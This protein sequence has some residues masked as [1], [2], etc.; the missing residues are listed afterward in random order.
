M[1]FTGFRLCENSAGSGI[2]PSRMNRTRGITRHSAPV[3]GIAVIVITLAIVAGIGLSAYRA[4]VHR[5]GDEQNATL[6]AIGKLKA[7]Q[8][9]QWRKNRAFDAW[10]LA[11]GKFLRSVIDRLSDPAIAE[12]LRQHL[13][14]QASPDG[15]NVLLFDTNGKFLLSSQPES[16]DE[17]STLNPALQ[18][19]VQAALHSNEAVVSDIYKCPF[20]KTHIDFTAA[21]PGP[22]GN[23]AGVL[24]L[25]SE[26][27]DFLYP[28]L[29]TWPLPSETAESLLAA[30][31]GDE[32]VFLNNLRHAPDAA[33]NLRLPMSRVDLPTVQW[34]SG[35]PEVRS[36][37]DY[38]GEPVFSNI[39]PIADSP[40]IIVAKIDKKEAFRDL[41][42]RIFEIVLVALLILLLAAIFVAALFI[43]RQRHI[44]QSLRMSEERLRRVIDASPVP[45]AVNNPRGEITYL[46]PA[47]TQAFGYT[48]K[49]IPNL[50]EW[51]PKAYPDPDYRKEVA[52]E[53]AARIEKSLSTGSPFEP[54]EVSVR[55][56]DGA[57]RTVLGMAAQMPEEAG[58]SLIVHLY[59]IT[60]RKESEIRTMRLARMYQALSECNQAIVQST[61]AG[62]LFGRVCR[63]VVES[64]GMKMAWVGMADQNA[65]FL[66]KIAA[67]GEGT[68]YLDGLKI[69]LSPVGAE[70]RGPAATSI[71]ENRPVWCQDFMGDPMTAPWHER[72]AAF[73]WAASAAL[74]LCKAGKPC[75]AFTFYSGQK[76]A[77]DEDVRNLLSEI[78]VNI[79]FAMDGFER[80]K[81]RRIAEDELAR[82]KD[83][84]A[85]VLDASPQAIFW[86]DANSI[87]LGCNKAFATNCG[88]RSPSGI[89]GKSDFDLPW[90]PEESAAYVADDKSVMSSRQPKL[91][92]IETQRDANGK[93]LWIDT[94]KVPLI[95]AAGAVWGVLGIFDDITERKLAEDELLR[96]RTA[97]EQSANIIVITDT[98]GKIQYVNPAFENATGYSASDAI[99]KRPSILSSH[100]Q[101]PEF[102][103]NLWDTITSGKIWRGEFH[104]IRKNGSLY[105]ESATISPVAGPDGTILNFIA[106][107]ED[108]T[109]RKEL[110]KNL[111]EAL[112]RAK[113]ANRAKGEFL[114]V[115]SHELRTP[116]NGV[117]GFGELLSDTALDDE[118]KEFVHTIQS[119]GTH[120]LQVVND[121]LDFSSIESK[122]VRLEKENVV[123]TEVVQSACNAV[124]KMAGDKGLAFHFHVATEA[125]EAIEGDPRR[126]R[127]ILLNLVGNAVKFTSAGSVVLRVEPVSAGEGRFVD[128]AIEDTGPGISPEVLGKLFKPFTQADSSLRRSFE[129]TG[130]GLAISQ[131]LAEAMGGGITVE[132][133]EGAGST[134][135]LRLPVSMPGGSISVNSGA[136]PFLPKAVLPPA[137]KRILVAEDDRVS[138]ILTKKILYA[139]GLKSDLVPDGRKA[140]DAFVP[141]KYSAILMDMQMPV[142]DGIEATLQIREVEKTAGGT[143][144]TRIIA[145]TANV[146]P[147]DRERC[148]AAGMDDFISKP[149]S[150]KELA[151]KL[152][153]T[154]S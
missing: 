109:A 87:Y 76:H 122:G 136:S 15:G 127:Q 140:L 5:I 144:R 30:R 116:L 60:A 51:W 33:L 70:G 132:S 25:R 88:L 102:Y 56:A 101:G 85:Q 150:K 53:W 138:A 73:G 19:A 38:R 14:L 77:F 41:P 59:D 72:G 95:D 93:S 142:M 37:I 82:S 149:F 48:T 45:F 71:V 78:A 2:R 97:V 34:F 137:P 22:D 65:A 128:F 66:E 129:G 20:G 113:S 110:E 9:E 126:I 24:V 13:N 17:N 119:C 92:I 54:Y 69:G 91:H 146:M 98:D 153:Y 133:T 57:M 6:A 114:A 63:I 58:T 46:N 36:G 118:Q 61:T 74:P 16:H 145:L 143:E 1:I 115:M 90:K 134:F 80:E 89:I 86:K 10:R 103:K 96:L 94:S 31:E 12:E 130:L 139:L 135:T 105:W 28:F 120:L 50:E 111:I 18:E 44:A 21:V 4:E 123:L 27:G 40:W 52:A 23:P 148:L 39:T 47:F 147:G 121:I 151:E 3:A 81:A 99:G 154:T 108:I 100:E 131:R 7:G 79:S 106:V 125:P 141:G 84:L 49:D 35:L 64:G 11:H 107:K 42:R 43:R 117:L 26:A 32:V 68:E 62:E 75:G 83:M 29:K 152:L 112:D 8:I 104:N 67:F 55:C 124:R